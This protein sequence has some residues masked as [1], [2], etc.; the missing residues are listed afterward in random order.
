MRGFT[1][2]VA[3]A[4]ALLL[5]GMAA[6]QNMSIEYVSR[7]DTERGNDHYVGNAAPLLPSPFYKLP[8][9][10]IQPRGWLG[11]QLDLMRDGQVGQ[12][13]RISPWC[14]K[15]G[16]AWLDPEGTGKAGWEE[17][18]YWLKGYGDL[19]YILDDKDMIAEALVWIEGILG[20]QRA[21][22]WFGPLEN[23]KSLDGAADL[24]PN[25]IALNCLQSY[26]EYT[27]DPR[28]IDFMT[29][30]FEWQLAVPE[31]R[32][33][34]GYWPA[35]RAGDNLESV[36]W[37]YNRTR[38]GR[39]IELAHKIPR[40]MA[41]WDE[42]VINWHGVNITQGFREPAEYYV[43]SHDP[44]HLDATVRNYDEVMAKYGQVPG[45][46]F[47]ADENARPGYDDPRQAAETCSMVEFMHSFQ[48]LVAMTGDPVWADRCEEVA[49]N[50][51]PAS[52]TPDLKSLHYLT[53]PNM[54]RLDKDD[55]SPGLQNSGT[56]LSYDPHGYRCCQHNV[57]HGW[58]YY[59][60]HLWMAAP[61]NGL[62]AM[63]YA[64][65]VVS[66]TVG[67]GVQIRITESTGYPFSEVIE[68]TLSPER[69]VEFPIFLRVPGWCESA[70]VEINGRAVGTTPP[71][72]S[73]VRLE[74]RWEPNDVVTLTLPM[75]IRVDRWLA[76]HQAAS[77]SR[78]P[79]TY[80]LA[81]DEEWQ[82]YGGTDEFPALEVFPRSPWNYGLV[83]SDEDP[84][85]GFTVL[86]SAEAVA[87]QPFTLEDAPVRLIT[88]GRRI[89]NWM[90]LPQMNLVDELQDSPV[91]SDEPVEEIV[92]VPM[93]CARLRISAFPVIG[94]DNDAHVWAAPPEPRHLASHVH[95][96]RAAVSD[97]IEPSSS[98][99]Q[100]IPRFTW[101]DHRGTEEWITYRL[102][103]P[104][105][106]SSVALYW[107]DDTTTA[108]RCR[109]PASWRLEYLREG[110]WVPVQ[111][112]GE[113]GVDADQYNRVEFGPVETEALRVTV[114]LQEDFSGGILEW[115]IN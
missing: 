67:D 113:Y 54:P 52:Q 61:G 53:A 103:E 36:Y 25:M 110:Q 65:S 102:D 44:A 42:G 66:A 93:G 64:E 74:R 87:R 91:A 114:R 78:G 34:R 24:W 106:V 6:A 23:E 13:P 96:S 83:L 48:M 63:L 94:T 71:P 85:A 115:K 35:I 101:W 49:F 10:S 76:N 89:P 98:N 41:R 27:S 100:S 77:V 5:T 39:L 8:V 62:A 82:R 112:L 47:G 15:E 108:G 2:M 50:D 104:G 9:G 95:D 86:E 28:V 12:L 73:Y 17:L 57:S 4:G 84:A 68:F 99:D 46:M 58:P 81:I 45:G 72:G 79:L 105:T 75:S 70:R 38:D 40:C 33:M 107:F 90:L 14:V 111:A 3:L 97:G 26:H 80:S 30:Y 109:V 16:N 19:A 59:A 20:S 69:A 32:F 22:G 18:P 31:D 1:A 37:L 29:R 51:F 7:P 60:E 21:D 43:L 55:K 56:M 11:H 88:K 92:L